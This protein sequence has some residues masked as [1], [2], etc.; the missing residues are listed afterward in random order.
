M[1]ISE[2]VHSWVRKTLQV[3]RKGDQLTPINTIRGKINTPIHSPKPQSISQTSTRERNKQNCANIYPQP[4]SITTR[5][6]NPHQNWYFCTK[7]FIESASSLIL[8]NLTK[9]NIT[10]S[11]LQPISLL[12]TYIKPIL[13]PPTT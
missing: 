4:H 6:H 9:H 7:Y 12:P 5:M 8:H 2:T 10:L 13:Q 11:S 3:T 1:P